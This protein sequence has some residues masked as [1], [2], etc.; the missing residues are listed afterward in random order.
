[1]VRE[2]FSYASK[3]TAWLP[4]RRMV[5][6]PTQGLAG[7]LPEAATPDLEGWGRKLQGSGWRKEKKNLLATERGV[8]NFC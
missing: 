6:G 2:G 7:H 8:A 3:T 4:Q 1:M 5:A